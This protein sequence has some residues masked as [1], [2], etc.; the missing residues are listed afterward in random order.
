MAKARAPV[1]AFS[2]FQPTLGKSLIKAHLLQKLGEDRD[3]RF[4]LLSKLET[5]KPETLGECLHGVSKDGLFMVE[6][7][8]EVDILF[9]FGSF[10]LRT[11]SD[12]IRQ[13]LNLPPL[14]LDRRVASIHAVISQAWLDF[15][16]RGNHTMLAELRNVDRQ[17]MI[18]SFVNLFQ[19]LYN[20]QFPNCDEAD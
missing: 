1:Q 10:L 12:E 14:V 5:S 13:H 19:N 2:A 18:E 20:V 11:P 9:E 8:T 16:G 15:V 17:A 3:I 7:S 6:S 4:L